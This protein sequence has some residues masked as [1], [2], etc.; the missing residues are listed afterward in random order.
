MMKA[1]LACLHEGT[2]KQEKVPILLAVTQLTST[3]EEMMRTDQGLTMSLNESVQHYA[4]Q[5][6]KSGLDGVVC[7]ALEVEMLKGK[8]GEDFVC[9]TPGIRPFDS[10]RGDQRTRCDTSTS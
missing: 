2:Q 3:S 4:T 10:Q 1:T 6:K 7:S 9:L 5:V 8:L